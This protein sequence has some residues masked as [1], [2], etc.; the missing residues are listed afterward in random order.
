[1]RRLL[2]LVVAIIVYGS[3]YPWQFTFAGR[4]EP[5]SVLLHSWPHAWDRF[6]TRDVAINVLLYMP[7]GA[8]ACLA[9][10]RRFPRAI[11]ERG[12]ELD[13]P[14]RRA[15]QDCSSR[16]QAITT[17]PRPSRSRSSQTQRASARPV[18]GPPRYALHR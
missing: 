1:M 3:L 16:F 11:D 8:V 2:L 9:W 15:G 14:R 12:L 13:A 7:L 10:L 4:P 18:R 6:V 17:T 5:V